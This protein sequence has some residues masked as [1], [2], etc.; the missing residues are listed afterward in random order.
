VWVLEQAWIVG[1]ILQKTEADSAAGVRM[2]YE[3]VE[4]IAV[5]SRSLG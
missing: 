1:Q 5:G 4:G 3:F 2:G